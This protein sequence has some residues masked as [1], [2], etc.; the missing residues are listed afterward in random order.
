MMAKFS[1]NVGR[2][3]RKLFPYVVTSQWSAKCGK[4]V[5]GLS[6]N[7]PIWLPQDYVVKVFVGDVNAEIVSDGNP[8]Q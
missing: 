1:A 6:Y 8:A 4:R 2:H 7:L 5:Y 3:C